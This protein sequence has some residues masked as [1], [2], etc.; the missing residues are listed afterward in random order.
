[1]TLT[2]GGNILYSFVTDDEVKSLVGADVVAPEPPKP[3][4]TPE[5]TPP[6]SPE[7]TPPES[8][9]QNDPDLAPE[10]EDDN[11]TSNNPV[12]KATMK[13]AG[14]GISL[15]LI[16]LLSVLGVFSRKKY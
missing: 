13:S 14:M 8:P 2:T 16:V 1:M 12:A 3:N 7:K 10:S 15:I 9:E 5:P 11:K 6:E 4:I